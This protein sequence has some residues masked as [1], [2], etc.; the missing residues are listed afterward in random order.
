MATNFTPNFKEP[1]E[2][3]VNDQSNIDI[4]NPKKRS[5]NSSISNTSV[6]YLEN[7][8]QPQQSNMESENRTTAVTSDNQKV[9]EENLAIF[10]ALRK[11]HM[12]LHRT[13]NHAAYL[14]RCCTQDII[15][16]TL[17]VK[18]IPQIPDSTAAFLLKWEEAHLNF[19]RSLI[20]L[21]S[22]YWNNRVKYIEQ[23]IEEHVKHWC[24]FTGQPQ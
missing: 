1:K 22:E 19:S 7:S 24:P 5:R 23:Q 6:K 18:I 3:T 12:K 4:S 17:R 9:S 11:L 13:K 21:L 8:T 2:D 20:R 15:P 16:K 10:R 14:E